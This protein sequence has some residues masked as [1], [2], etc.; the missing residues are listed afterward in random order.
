MRKS[1]RIIALVLALTMMFTFMAM[2]ASAATVELPII[3]PKA[4]CGHCGS[5]S[6]RYSYSRTESLKYLWKEDA[7]CNYMSAYH[8]HFKVPSVMYTYCRTCGHC[9]STL[10]YEAIYCPHGGY[11]T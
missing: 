9:V 10:N 5:S 1:K 2:S 7:T 8:A 4:T 11:L 3:S 6:F